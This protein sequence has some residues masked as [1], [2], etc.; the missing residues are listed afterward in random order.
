MDQKSPEFS[1][2]QKIWSILWSGWPLIF[3]KKFPVHFNTF[4]PTRNRLSVHTSTF[5]AKICVREEGEDRH[6]LNT[7]KK[8]PKQ[9]KYTMDPG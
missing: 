9:D 3:L 8:A 6:S 5:P 2:F 4:T 1:K 7:F